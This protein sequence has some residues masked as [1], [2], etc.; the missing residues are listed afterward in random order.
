MPAKGRLRAVGSQAGSRTGSGLL[1]SW[2]SWQTLASL[3]DL[4]LIRKTGAS[5]R[6]MTHFE[7]PWVVSPDPFKPVAWGSID[8]AVIGCVVRL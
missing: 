6:A 5:R 1:S 8:L 7:R 3:G 4:S 2:P